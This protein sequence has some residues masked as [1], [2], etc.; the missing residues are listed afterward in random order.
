MDGL[1]M[2]G[3]QG[4]VGD[5]FAFEVAMQ[6]NRWQTTMDRYFKKQKK[7]KASPEDGVPQARVIRR[8]TSFQLLKKLRTMQDNPVTSLQIMHINKTINIGKAPKPEGKLREVSYTHHG[9]Y[10][11]VT[12]KQGVHNM[13]GFNL[14]DKVQLENYISDIKSDSYAFDPALPGVKFPIV[15]NSGDY[16]IY[17]HS[18]V[19]KFLLTNASNSCQKVRL[20]F[21]LAS[22]DMDP[23]YS[24]PQQFWETQEGLYRFVGSTTPT[25]DI[26]TQYGRQPRGISEGYTKLEE[27]VLNMP[28]FANYE[29]QVNIN[30]RKFFSTD[31]FALVQGQGACFAGYTVKCMAINYGTA[32]FDASN[33]VTVN[34]VKFG[35]CA[36]T[37]VKYGIIPRNAKIAVIGNTLSSGNPAVVGTT[38]GVSEENRE[39]L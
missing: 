10:T 20:I 29:A 37:T 18:M 11:S 9:S 38:T 14:F 31:R 36:S 39:E 34:G 8:L 30:M 16:S 15:P 26:I 27:M 21:Y 25:A 28:P 7:R 19:H 3:V 13:G 33:N 35:Y 23:D 32:Q 24:L 5:G 12:G 2:A 22:T 6:A 1:I 4:V 17:L